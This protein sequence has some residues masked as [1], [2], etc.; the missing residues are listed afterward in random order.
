[1]VPLMR[2]ANELFDERFERLLPR[3]RSKGT[4]AD[5]DSPLS[6]TESIAYDWL[7]HGGKRFR[8]F[9]TLA[10]YDAARGGEAVAAGTGNFVPTLPDAVCRV[11][12]AIE[13]FHKASLVHDDIEDDDVYRYG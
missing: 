3:V 10:A 12:M 4:P 6:A 5:L 9:I 2:A 8:P 1:Y 13:A 11:A 7:A